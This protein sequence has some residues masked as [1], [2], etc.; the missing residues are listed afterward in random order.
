M[1]KLIK[2]TS[3]KTVV[4]KNWTRSSHVLLLLPI[5]PNRKRHALHLQQENNFYSA[6]QE[7]RISSFSGIS[8]PV[9]DSHNLANKKPLHFELSVSSNIVFIYNSAFQLS[10][11]SSLFSRLAYG[12]TIACT[13]QIAIIYFS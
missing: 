6:T 1:Q 10:L 7:D 12:C 9:T 4:R 5:A 3:I 8:A 2:E 13:S 11:I